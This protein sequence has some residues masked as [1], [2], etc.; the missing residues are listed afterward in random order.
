MS[1]NFHF[2]DRVIMEG[3]VIRT[4][5]TLAWIEMSCGDLVKSNVGRPVLGTLD[6]IGR[7]ERFWA[8]ERDRFNGVAPPGQWILARRALEELDPVKRSEALHGLVAACRSIA[9]N[10]KIEDAL[11]VLDESVTDEF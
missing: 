2:G 7:L 4:Q 6:R 10:R 11:R 5:G 3:K 9:G 8:A 1:D